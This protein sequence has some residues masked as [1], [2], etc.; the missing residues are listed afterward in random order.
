VMHV[1]VPDP[2]VAGTE[3]RPHLEI[4]NKLGQPVVAQ[5]LVMTIEDDR[6]VTKGLSASPHKGS[7]HYGFSY[8]FPRPGHYVMRVF[9]PSV[10]SS[11]VIPL[12]VR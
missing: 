11:F 5:Q 3:V 9:P 1:L 2:I 4:H 8:T 6:H 12:D 7:G 10:D